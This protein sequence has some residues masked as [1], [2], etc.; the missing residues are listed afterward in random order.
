MEETSSDSL[1]DTKMQLCPD[2]PA[3]TRNTIPNLHAAATLTTLIMS[4]GL[5]AAQAQTN[6]PS[7]SALGTNALTKL[8]EVVVKGQRQDSYRPEALSSPLY[9]EPLRDIPQ[10][11]MV[12]PP[13]VIEAQGVNSLRDVLRNVPGIS[14]QAGEGGGGL[15]GD[16]L[17]IRGFNSRSDIFVDGLRDFGAYSRDP[18][19]LEQVEIS[20]G[21]SSA[22]AGRGATGGSIN[23]VT[24]RPRLTPLY[25][26]S[27]G[28]G[29]DDFKRATLDLNQPLQAA[30]L[31]TSAIRLNGLW[32]DAGVPGRDVVEEKRWAI[33]P[34]VAFGLG[35]PTRVTFDYIHMEQD[36]VPQ[37]GI[38]WVPA[39]NT[40]AVL[41]RYVNKASPVDF[42]NFYGLEDYDFEDIRNDIVTA[43]VDHDFTPELRLRNVSRFSDTY[44]NHAIT[45]PRFADIDPGPDTVSDTLVNRQLQ[46]RKLEHTAYA[47]ATDLTWDFETGPITHALIG[48][49]EV[50]REDQDNRNS[51]QSTNQPQTDIFHPSPSDQPFGPMPS[52]SGI[53]NE[54]NATTI[55]P[56]IFDTLKLGDQWQVSGGFRFDYVES[57]FQSGT[58]RLDRTDDMLSWRAGVVYKPRP[59]GSIYFGYGTSFTPSIAAGNAG[60]SL[61]AN[62]VELE[63]E[64]S[65]SFEL[66]TK[67]DIFNERL[68]LGAALFRTEKTSARTPG[69]NP[70]DPP[71]VLDGEQIVQGIEVYFAGS[72]TD[73][74]KVF[75]GY[76]FMDSEIKESNA[77]N[78]AGAEFGNT[79]DHSF[80]L[81]TAYT[82]PHGIEVG[83]GAQYVGNRFNN[84]SGNANVRTAPDY[85]LFDAMLG[86][87]VNEHVALRLNV[88]NL[89]DKE[90][91][92]RVGGGHS[93]PGT[94]RFALLTANFQF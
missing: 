79:P 42:S 7:G 19:N 35:T 55:A 68:S 30:G 54:A 29:S 58:N 83:L 89:T 2:M 86:Y 51:A 48:G 11:V 8:P 34:S 62:D 37:Y 38:P 64:E 50:S 39:G 17:S 41:S 32:H 74:W 46:R 73:H 67:W 10:T 25:G 63:P 75:G 72:I 93:I 15:P 71:L 60:L 88:Q 31:E 33:N 49:L 84:Q 23:L 53:A 26:G 40:N 12:I 5:A 3:P 44:R 91:I 85:L 9:T 28:F 14:M 70:G 27:L 45:A 56:F 92:D 36:N 24:K 1:T 77:A 94:G 18:F 47:N 13:A 61:S 22:T 69:V 65:R 82:L 76:T 20:K 57:D 52:I 81:W 21:P 59:N 4:N 6:A 78:E 66:G 43:I 80:S 87:R 90:Y 16:N